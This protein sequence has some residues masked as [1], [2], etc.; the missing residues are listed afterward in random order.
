MCSS[1][2]E[3]EFE[4]IVF[5]FTHSNCEHKFCTIFYCNLKWKIAHYLNT[6]LDFPLVLSGSL[7]ALSMLLKSL[8]ELPPSN[9]TQRLT[10]GE[11]GKSVVYLRERLLTES[12]V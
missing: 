11:N 3:V 2:L 9:A 7:C 12:L 4:L 5:K 10:K 8:T 1:L 6:A